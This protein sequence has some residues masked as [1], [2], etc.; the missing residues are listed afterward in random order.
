MIEILWLAAVVV[1]IILEAVT[2]QMISVWFIIG[3]VG[4]LIAV[5]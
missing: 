4:A 2:Y 1:F 5:F 3:S